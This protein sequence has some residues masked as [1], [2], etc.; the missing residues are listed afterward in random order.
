M[1]WMAEFHP[2][3]S[4]DVPAPR[5]RAGAITSGGTDGFN[6]EHLRNFRNAAPRVAFGIETQ[7]GHGASDARGEYTLRRNTFPNPNGA[8]P[9]TPPPIPAGQEPTYRLDSVGGTTYGGTG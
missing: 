4:Y 3:G 6:E 2:N 1:K 7:P 9:G 5:R 8:P